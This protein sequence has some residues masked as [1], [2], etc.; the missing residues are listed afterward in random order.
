MILRKPT[1]PS[2]VITYSNGVE[3]QGASSVALEWD[4]VF[5]VDIVRKILQYLGLSVG[6][7]LILE[8]VEN[9]NLKEK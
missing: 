5:H 7:Q 3:T 2:L 6:N 9:Q 8:A 1:T 4:S